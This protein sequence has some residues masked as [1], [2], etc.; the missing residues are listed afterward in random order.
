M[1]RIDLQN[2]SVGNGISYLVVESL[3]ALLFNPNLQLNHL[4]LRIHNKVADKIEASKEQGFVDLED[5]EFD[6]L[7]QSVEAYQNY[8]RNDMKLVEQIMGL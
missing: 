4:R 8:S 2:Y 5:A 7:K 6:I 3:V 1:K